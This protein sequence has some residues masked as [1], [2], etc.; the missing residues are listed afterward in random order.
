MI[1]ETRDDAWQADNIPL[2]WQGD[3]KQLTILSLDWTTGLEFW[4]LSLCRNAIKRNYIKS[5]FCYCW[6]AGRCSHQRIGLWRPATAS[7]LPPQSPAIAEKKCKNAQMASRLIMKNNLLRQKWWKGCATGIEVRF[8][9]I[10]WA[11][12]RCYPISCPAYTNPPPMH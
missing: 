5:A 10:G 6:S 2:A 3:S 11:C 4:L 9:S 8:P 12:Q 1:Q 7:F